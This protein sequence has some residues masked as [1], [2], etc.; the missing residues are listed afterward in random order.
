[1]IKEYDKVKLRTGEIA[2]IVEILEQGKRYIGEIVRADKHVDIDHIPFDD[3]ISV[4]DEV[5]RPLHKAV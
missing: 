5:E 1:M 2:R 4:F 3:I